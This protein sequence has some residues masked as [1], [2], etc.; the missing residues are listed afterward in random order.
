MFG[1]SSAKAGVQEVDTAWI[2][3]RCKDE[4]VNEVDFTTFLKL[5]AL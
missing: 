3:Q 2:K 4:G 1:K 5:V